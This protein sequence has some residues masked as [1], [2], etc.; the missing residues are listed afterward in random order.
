MGRG[1]YDR[2]LPQC[3]NAAKVLV[4]FEAQRLERVFTEGR[5]I[6]MDAAV[7]EAGLVLFPAETNCA[8]KG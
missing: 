5:D 4:A 7:T 3:L 8:K 6:P 2:F 1:Y